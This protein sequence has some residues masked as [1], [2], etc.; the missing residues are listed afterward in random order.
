LYR[1]RSIARLVENRRFDPSVFCAPLEVESTEISARS[2]A[3]K[4]LES[5]A[6]LLCSVDCVTI[7]SAV[8]IQYQRVADGRTDE[9][10]D[11][12]TAIAAS[13]FA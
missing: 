1:S 2:F 9:R 8:L 12:Q 7:G 13:Y 6:R 3:P 10:M 11:G 4:K 5:L